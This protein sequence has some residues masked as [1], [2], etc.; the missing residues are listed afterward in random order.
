MR[1]SHPY[2][3]NILLNNPV[4]IG[5][6]SLEKIQRRTIMLLKLN[7]AVTA[8]LPGPLRPWC[9]VV[10]LRKGI[11]ILETAN[12]TWKMRLRYEQ[13]HLLSVLRLQILPS[14]SSIN[15]K[16]NP[17]LAIKEN[18][19]FKKNEDAKPYHSIL[20]KPKTLSIQSAECIRH[21]AIHSEGT[22]K[23]ALERL[24]KLVEK[25]FRSTIY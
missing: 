16:I 9:R 8:L 23:N 13:T 4:S 3:I 18:V 1:N 2:S 10:N 7:K 17:L 14:L 19:N 21:M 24:A 5:Q 12:A 25:N 15:I 20:E 22:L 11:M 6:I